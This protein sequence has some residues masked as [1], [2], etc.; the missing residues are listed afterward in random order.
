MYYKLNFDCL[1]DFINIVFAMGTWGGDG[2]IVCQEK[3]RFLY[4]R[5]TP[6]SRHK[7]NSVAE[8]LPAHFFSSILLRVEKTMLVR[9]VLKQAVVDS[10]QHVY[11]LDE[12]IEYGRAQHRN[13]SQIS[14]ARFEWPAKLP[15]IALSVHML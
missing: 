8:M 4:S 1:P 3:E 5:T 6:T 9:S 11:R 12:P 13:A 10:S 7:S 15:A 2:V 14:W